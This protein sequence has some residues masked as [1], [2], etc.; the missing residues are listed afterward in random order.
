MNTLVNEVRSLEHFSELQR[1]IKKK[2]TSLVSNCYLLPQAI[3]DITSKHKLFFEESEN[4]LFFLQEKPDF[5]SLFFYIQMSK[6]EGDQLNILNVGKPIIFDFAYQNLDN[7]KKLANALK[8]YW[9]RKGFLLYSRYRQLSISIAEKNAD[10]ETNHWSKNINNKYKFGFAVL[11]EAPKI[12]ELWR[13]SLDIY[14]TALPDI[15]EINAWMGNQE[16]IACRDDRNELIAALL[17]LKNGK[18]ATINHVVVSEKFRNQGLG[19]A[20]LSR[21]IQMLDAIDK[22]SLWVEENNIPAR[23][24]YT[25]YG[26]TYTNKLSDQFLF[27]SEKE[28]IKNGKTYGNP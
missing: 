26:F 21:S 23:T 28:I 6:G 25:K 20:L 9:A 8:H 11:S 2:T 13:H 15:N 10:S 17:V 19:M 5:Y 22:F 14:S 4:G 7:L 18:T 1:T 12:L 16:V 24:L 27:N 3:A